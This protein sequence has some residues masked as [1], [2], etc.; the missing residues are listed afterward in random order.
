MK[1]LVMNILALTVLS[2]P[3]T[4][5]VADE[6]SINTL[7]QQYQAAGAKSGDANRGEALWN[8][9]YTGK[10]P[11]T[12]RSCKT[13]HTANVKNPG[14]HIR[15]GKALKPLAPSANPGSLIKVKKIKKWFKR[16]CKWTLGKECSVQQK[17][18]ILTFLKT[19]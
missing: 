18:D 10:A 5:A 17:A 4:A 14:K 8:K 15:T 19:Q 11:F 2:I 3:V 1:N 9:S 12:E 16:N 13:C 6:T 7:L